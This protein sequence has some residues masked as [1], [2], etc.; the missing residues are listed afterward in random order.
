MITLFLG[1]SKYDPAKLWDAACK[2][3]ALLSIERTRVLHRSIILSRTL[4]NRR[5]C[6]V[7]NLDAD[8]K[9]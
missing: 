9:T 7:P 5:L 6:S 8:Q 2:P 3:I 1:F 4:V